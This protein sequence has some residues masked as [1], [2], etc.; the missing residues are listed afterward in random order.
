MT[1]P[2]RSDYYRW[3]SYASSLHC[4]TCS[5][6]VMCSDYCVQV[7]DVP[8]NYGT[9]LQVEPMQVFHT[10]SVVVLLRLDGLLDQGS[11]GSV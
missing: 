8:Y 11:R 9:A 10:G 3:D 5:G 4:R 2:L 1:W 6:T 7:T